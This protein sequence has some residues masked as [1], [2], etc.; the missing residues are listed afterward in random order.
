MTSIIGQ[1]STFKLYINE[2]S[3]LQI[4]DNKVEI[5][6]QTAVIQTEKEAEN[7]TTGFSYYSAFAKPTY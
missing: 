4:K 6:M 5:L 7:Q 3:K 2:P 1:I